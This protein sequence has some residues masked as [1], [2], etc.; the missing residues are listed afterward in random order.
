[1]KRKTKLSIVAT[2]II[3]VAALIFIGCNKDKLLK[4]LDDKNETNQTQKVI[5]SM[6]YFFYKNG[7][8]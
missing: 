5:S 4:E 2:S 7:H 3:A 1:M 8:F 6:L